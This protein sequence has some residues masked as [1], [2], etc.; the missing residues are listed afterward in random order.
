MMKKALIYLGITALI[1]IIFSVISRLS[2]AFSE[3]YATNIYPLIV[4]VFG[5]I[6]GVF[7]FAVV[8]ILFYILILAA[9][10]GI[11]FLIIR[12]IN[13]KGRRR[14]IWACA[15]LALACTVSTLL[16]MF[17]FGGGINYQ[18]RPFSYYSGLE[19]EMYSE[20]DLRNV[21]IEVIGE[22]ELLVPLIDTGEDGGFILDRRG[23]N[24]TARNA[25]RSLAELY[26]VLDTYYPSPKPVLFSR[27]IISPLMIGGIFSP[28]TMEALYNRDMP[29][30]GIPFV[31]LHE[32]SH[33]SGFMREDEANFIAFLACRESGDI[34]FMYSGYDRALWSLLNVYEGEDLYELYM[35]VP[36][37]VRLQAHLDGEYWRSFRSRP[38]GE[39]I[40]AMASAVND[41]YLI[42]QGQEDGVQSYGRVVDLLIADYLA[43]KNT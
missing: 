16:L 38:G 3:W 14:R 4:G 18:R 10:A 20:E 9:L 1:N 11:V 39:A 36:E 31:A 15:G 28:F 22:L 2:P 30:S 25:M 5:R 6:S 23:F 13:G 21:I 26:P 7:P 32:L 19:I 29:D 34:G 33:L 24:Q 8:E 42:M 27:Q 17:T 37:Q 35:S 43:R 40:A 12:L 41:A